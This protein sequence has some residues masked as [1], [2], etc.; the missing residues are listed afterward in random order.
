VNSLYSTNAGVTAA[1]RC[2]AARREELRPP[3]LCKTATTWCSLLCAG[4][5]GG[6]ASACAILF[7][8][9]GQANSLLWV[10]N[11]TLLLAYLNMLAAAHHVLF[12]CRAARKG[13]RLHCNLRCLVPAPLRGSPSAARCLLLDVSCTMENNVRSPSSGACY[14]LSAVYHASRCCLG[15]AFQRVY[16]PSANG[17]MPIHSIERVPSYA[18]SV[19]D[20]AA[21]DVSCHAHLSAAPSPSPG[22][23][24][25]NRAWGEGRQR[26]TPS[27]AL[28]HIPP[29]P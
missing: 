8:C 15:D 14:L 1:P 17:V 13:E 6:S 27:G 29:A 2:L 20:G 4:G 23:N 28:Y 21:R 10:G 25:R 5:H 9:G 7:S 22:G 12:A 18:I 16:L 3:Q 19:L 26:W 11:I 24:G